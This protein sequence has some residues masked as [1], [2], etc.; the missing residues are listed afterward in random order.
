[1]HKK[2]NRNSEI[3]FQ[4]FLKTLLCNFRQKFEVVKYT[5]NNFVGT[6]KC[7][8][9]NNLKRFFLNI[10]RKRKIDTANY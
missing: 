10:S 7:R 1:M 3:S 9:K 5:Q 2:F 6:V 8:F 4:H